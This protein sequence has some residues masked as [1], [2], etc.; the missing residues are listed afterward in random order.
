MGLFLKS[1]LA[2]LVRKAGACILVVAVG[3]IETRANEESYKEMESWLEEVEQLLNDSGTATSGFLGGLSGLIATAQESDQRQAALQA[4]V[5]VIKARTAM[6]R[7]WEDP[8]LR[9]GYEEQDGQE[10]INRGA[11][12]RFR[13][14]DR[15]ERRLLEKIS[16]VDID[17]VHQKINALKGEIALRVKRLYARGIFARMRLLSEADHL[18]E[19][20][21]QERQLGF[22]KEAGQSS[23]VEQARLVLEQLKL[24]RSLRSEFTAFENAINELVSLGIGTAQAQGAFQSENWSELIVEQLPARESLVTIAIRNSGD[25]LKYNRE[26]AMLSIRLNEVKRSWLPSPSF[27]QLRWGDRRE[28]GNSIREEE[29]GALAG[30][31]IDLFDDHEEELLLSIRRETD[32]NRNVDLKELEQ[33]VKSRFA[34][35]QSVY[36]SYE[37][38]QAVYKP[39]V[40]SIETMLNE[41]AAAGGNKKALWDIRDDLF[42]LEGEFLDMRWMLVES[43]LKFESSLGQLLSN[44]E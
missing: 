23:A 36:N 15:A 30:F 34:D 32:L 8:E 1:G 27:F 5:E 28:T 44:G 26:D 12:I 40:T 10:Q 7:S 9:L 18:K 16:Q 38:Y 3:I 24:Y 21:E 33:E 43:Q 4:H 42:D 17:W 22:L 39:A 20:L 11:A 37:Q 19:L 31:D 2:G 35:V 14:P 25:T 29:W 41:N 6:G 13:L